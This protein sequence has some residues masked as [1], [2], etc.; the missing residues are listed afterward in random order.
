MPDV[1]RE[2][3]RISRECAV[4]RARQAARVLSRVYD[5]KMRSL[6]IQTS[7]FHVL[8]AVAA[9]GEPGAPMGKLADG[10]LVDRTTLTRNVV[11]L[12]KAGLLRVAR[13]PGD[14]RS[15]V[16]LITPA[17]ERLLL[18][19]LPLWEA[20][21]RAVRAALGGSRFDSLRNQLTQVVGLVTE[22]DGAKAR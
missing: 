16:L 18:Q 17:G 15:K 19:A 14:K 4:H 7:Q 1:T 3:Q 21:Q 6:G 11:P 10:L 20:A 9:Q 12:E 13:D 5:E 22:I 8:V 2:A